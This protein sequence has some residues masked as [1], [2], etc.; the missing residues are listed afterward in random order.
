MKKTRYNILAFFLMTLVTT[1]TISC[2]KFALDEEE[3]ASKEISEGKETDE[4]HANVSIHVSNTGCCRMSFAIFDVE[5]KIV[6]INQTKDNASFGIVH[7]NLDDGEYRLV[8]IAHNGK[9]NC[10]ISQPESIK[11][12]NNK[13]TDTFYYYGRLDVRGEKMEKNIELERAVAAFHVHI[14]EDMIPD[15]LKVIKFN[16][17]GGSSTLDATTGY[18]CVNSRQTESFKISN[19]S[20]DFVIFT[21]PHDV[22]SVNMDISFL[23]ADAEI[24]KHSYDNTLSMKINHTYNWIFSLKDNTHTNSWWTEGVWKKSEDNTPDYGEGNNQGNEG[25][26]QT[27]HDGDFDI[28]YGGL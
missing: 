12:T 13:L 23:N 17:T 21:F 20:R 18:G 2:E 19:E 24:V 16:Y 28:E 5:D 22:G 3:I 11:F 26:D 25:D 27:D 8:I 14:H 10:S 6:T 4:A 9:G 1:T 15:S 7:L